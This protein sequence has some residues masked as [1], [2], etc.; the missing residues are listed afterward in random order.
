[1]IVT[2]P[3]RPEHQGTYKITGQIADICPKCGG[4]R[5]PVEQGRSYDGSLYMS[6]DM[7]RNPCGHI[8]YYDDVRRE[9]EALKRGEPVPMP[10]DLSK[11]E[12]N[13]IKEALKYVLFSQS[14]YDEAQ[15]AL[16]QCGLSAEQARQI[17]EE[18]SQEMNTV[19]QKH[20]GLIQTIRARWPFGG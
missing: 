14:R 2:I 8:D 18:I 12:S 16:M 10:E 20:Q 17:L 9:M 7:W 1:M 11:R 4:P 19:L 6:V 3:A 13:R 15:E 5:G